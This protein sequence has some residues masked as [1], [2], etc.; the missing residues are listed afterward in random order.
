MDFDDIGV[1]GKLAFQRHQNPQNPFWLDCV[2]NAAI[3]TISK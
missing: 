2:D 1:V 3:A